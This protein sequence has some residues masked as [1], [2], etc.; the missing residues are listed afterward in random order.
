[1]VCH[2]EMNVAC[3]TCNTCKEE[4]PHKLRLK[5]KLKKFDQ[6]RESW[7]DMQK[8]NRTTSHI[9]DEAVLLVC[10]CFHCFYAGYAGY[11]PN[12]AIYIFK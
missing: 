5:K 6:K 8:K 12:V 1:M 3:K 2:T 10:D 9:Q 7:V 11:F 4:Q